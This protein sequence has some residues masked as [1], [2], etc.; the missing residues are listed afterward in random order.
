MLKEQI[1]LW[2]VE[3]VLSGTCGN[4]GAP[5]SGEVRMVWAMPGS[6]WGW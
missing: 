6:L 4:W 1:C 5:V 2:D 3:R